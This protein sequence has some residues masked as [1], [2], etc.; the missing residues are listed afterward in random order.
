MRIM[1]TWGIPG[2]QPRW[3]TKVEDLR[4]ALRAIQADFV[5]RPIR[6]VWT[7]WD[8]EWWNDAPVIIDAGSSRLEVCAHKLD[9]MSVSV[10]TIDISKPVF[11]CG[12]EEGGD[13][14]LRWTDRI[15]SCLAGIASQRIEGFCIMEYRLFPDL[16]QMLNL[17]WVVA[18][19][20]LEFENDYFEVSNG[21]DCN[22]LSR[23]RTFG[24]DNR[25]IEIGS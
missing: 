8:D 13:P 3:L 21:L 15:H 9:E 11:W 19:I 16:Q 22:A 5:G 7:L 6:A 18:G 25:Y 1:S 10:N 23:S 12:E 20:G 4:D 14:A 24:E 17:N 2:F